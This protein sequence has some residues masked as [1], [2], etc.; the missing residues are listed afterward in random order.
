MGGSEFDGVGLRDFL[1]R[2]QTVGKT[3]KARVQKPNPQSTQSIPPFSLRSNV[4]SPKRKP[5]NNTR[6]NSDRADPVSRVAQ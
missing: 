2:T 4:E 5:R 3:A 1:C 6:N